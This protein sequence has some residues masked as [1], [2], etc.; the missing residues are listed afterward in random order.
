[1]KHLVKRMLTVLLIVTMCILP[2]LATF[3][4]AEEE[5]VYYYGDVDE[6]GNIDK[7]DYILVKRYCL[8][9]VTFNDEQ[10]VRGDV[11]GSG[12]IDK[13]DYIIIKRHCLET[14]EIPKVP[15]PGTGSGDNSGD[16]GGDD[17]VNIKEDPTYANVALN[18]SYTKAPLYPSY[19]PTYVD[20]DNKE[21]TDGK[22]PAT[23]GGYRDPAFMAFNTSGDYYRANGYVHVTV[24]LGEVYELD[25]LVAY[26]GS[27]KLGSGIGAPAFV[28]FLVS[29][30]G[31]EWYKAGVAYIED[32]SDV[33]VV[34]STLNLKDTLTA[35]YVQYQI[36]AGSYNWM[37]V[38]EVE[39]Y[40]V[41]AKAAVEY[42]ESDPIKFLF[43][44]NSATYYFNVPDKLLFIAESA[45][46]EIDVTYCCIGSAYLSQFADANDEARGKLLRSKIA[47]KDYDYIV[48]QDNSNCDY[49]D[50]KAALDILV[51]YLRSAEPNAEILLYERYSSNTDPNQRPI[52]GKRLHN[53]YTQLAKDFNIEK[54]AH[55]SDAFLLCYEKYPSIELHHT[56]NS[57]HGE[58]AGAYLIASVMAIEFLDIDLDR[59]TYTSGLKADTVTALKEIA[60]LACTEGYPFK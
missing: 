8:E 58:G 50:T 37:F 17:D 5:L 34:T 51:P 46:V 22:Q 54:Q 55:V 23:S 16:V 26:L 57:H 29:N 31:D 32:S 35:R 45:G 18:K 27:K 3:A 36:V 7:F 21:M 56:D 25:T 12:D 11:D 52:S 41:K 14:I 4:Q 20:T 28:R 39:A 60:N 9:T 30:D 24:D 59:V 2:T 33:N 6:N 13:F 1:M 40:G 15:V 38:S 48:L 19:D 47:E 43:V 44:G 42:P 53:A 49:E 10:L